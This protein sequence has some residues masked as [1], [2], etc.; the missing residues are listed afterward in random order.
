MEQ[1]FIKLEI[2]QDGASNDASPSI[3]EI[4]EFTPV[5]SSSSEASVGSTSQGGARIEIRK[6]YI[7]AIN[8]GIQLFEEFE[9]DEA[10]AS[11]K[12]AIAFEKTNPEGYA[13]AADV[14]YFV[15]D[16]LLAHF[17]YKKALTY[18][19][20]NTQLSEL[21]QWTKNM[22]KPDEN[23][24]EEALQ[25]L[26]I[27]PNHPWANYSLFY[28]TKDKKY[29]DVLKRVHE[30][31]YKVALTND[32]SHAEAVPIIL[33]YIEE[34][35]AT[36]KK[37]EKPTKKYVVKE[38]NGYKRIVKPDSNEY[39]DEL[40]NQAISRSI[41]LGSLRLAFDLTKRHQEQ[42]INGDCRFFEFLIQIFWNAPTI[43]KQ[44]LLDLLI[45]LLNFRQDN[46]GPV[47]G[48]I[49]AKLLVECKQ[50]KL[51]SRIFGVFSI[52]YILTDETNLDFCIDRHEM[53]HYVLRAYYGY[54]EEVLNGPQTGVDLSKFTFKQF[55]TTKETE[56]L[57][58]HAK[59]K[60][61]LELLF[62]FKHFEKYLK[63][64]KLL[65]DDKVL[66]FSLEDSNQFM[67]F[68]ETKCEIIIWAI[69][70]IEDMIY[71]E[72]PQISSNIPPGIYDKDKSFKQ[73]SQIYDQL[74]TETFN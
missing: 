74:Y 37:Y 12:K 11:F 42:N 47:L 33:K 25:T 61:S 3:E 69:K 4:D 59:P 15:M 23:G 6:Q 27:D 63:N 48:L 66:A 21:I 55:F 73:V 45:K 57:T 64:Y 18:D 51:A 60:T 31:L 58:Q 16:P 9:V 26:S 67:E 17:N 71:F 44:E 5:N 36:G 65:A 53:S 7:K 70:T 46:G 34:E 24:T 38:I 19:P 50:Y 30:K 22:I 56:Y 54:V 32:I 49:R 2:S 39:L 1:E 68:I 35:E 72:L 29:L 62:A 14:Y 41:G 28:D 10:L 8:Q 20:K 43:S 52:P 40:Y 13:L